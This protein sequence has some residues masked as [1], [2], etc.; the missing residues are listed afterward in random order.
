MA[1]MA[2]NIHSLRALTAMAADGTAFVEH[3]W[4]ISRRGM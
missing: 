1:E 4:W 3:K 2:M